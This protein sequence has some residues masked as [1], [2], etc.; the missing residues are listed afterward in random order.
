[1]QPKVYSS[2]GKRENAAVRC[3]FCGLSQ[4]EV[5]KLV[6]GPPPAAICDQCLAA[7]YEGMYG[8]PPPPIPR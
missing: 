2:P 4:H 6:L 3:A 5:A 1:M 7:A 8:Q